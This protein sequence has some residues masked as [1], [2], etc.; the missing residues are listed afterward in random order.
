MLDPSILPHG[1]PMLFF[2]NSL[3]FVC[4]TNI[5]FLFLCLIF[6]SALSNLLLIPHSTFSFQ[7]LHFSSLEVPLG[8]FLYPL[9]LL[10][11]YLLNI[12]SIF[13]IVALMPCLFNLQAMLFLGVFLLNEFSSSQESYIHA[14]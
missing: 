10:S 11:T 4:F 1:L 2:F 13:I 7:I 9:F 6:S 3:F 8:A 14:C 5:Q 12:W